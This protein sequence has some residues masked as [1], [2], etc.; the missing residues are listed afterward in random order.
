MKLASILGV[1]AAGVFVG[2]VIMEIIHRTNPDL[3]KK[4]G[5]RTRN[6]FRT[7]GDAFREGY[8]GQPAAGAAPGG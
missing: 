7:I 6:A 2:A 5:E 3:M 4:L 1:G 8:S